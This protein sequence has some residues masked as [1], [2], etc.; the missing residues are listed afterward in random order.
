[1]RIS[2]ESISMDLD[3][4][5]SDAF[6]LQDV[7]REWVRRETTALTGGE[8]KTFF[9]VFV[10]FVLV[11]ILLYVLT[12]VMSGAA[13]AATMITAATSKIR[14]L[15]S[16]ITPIADISENV[17]DVLD[18]IVLAKKHVDIVSLSPVTAAGRLVSSYMTVLITNGATRYIETHAMF[19]ANKEVG[20][21]VVKFVKK[22]AFALLTMTAGSA[23]VYTEYSAFLT[24]MNLVCSVFPSTFW[25]KPE[26]K[27]TVKIDS[28]PET[29]E[30]GDPQPGDSQPVDIRRENRIKRREKRRGLFAK[31][32]KWLRQ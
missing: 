31:L 17:A 15:F 30:P 16:S 19:K 8:C 4:V 24:V 14:S 7:L 13:S 26:M 9:D 29:D 10:V 12:M 27:K 28:V 11:C 6:S 23:G 22:K 32:L 20:K 21:G 1:M 18:Q 25:K 5:I 3:T 2:M